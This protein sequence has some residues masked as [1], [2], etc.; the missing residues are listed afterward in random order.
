MTIPHIKLFS[1]ASCAGASFI[2]TASLMLWRPPKLDRNVMARMSAGNYLGTAES[3]RYG[4]TIL[5]APGGRVQ[6][7]IEPAPGQS[8]D[9]S[10]RR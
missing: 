2:A 10:T 8:R 3:N 1:S 6:G 4:D 7:T 5:R 9:T